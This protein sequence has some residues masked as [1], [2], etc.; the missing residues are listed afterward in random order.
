MKVAQRA[1]LVLCVFGCM[2]VASAAQTPV[3][4]LAVDERQGDQYGWAVD[5]ETAAAARARALG[6]DQRLVAVIALVPDHLGDSTTGRQHRFHLLGRR[7]QRLDHR[8]RVAGIGVLDGHADDRTRFQVH[9]WTDV[10]LWWPGDEFGGRGLAPEVWSGAAGVS[11]RRGSARLR[12][13]AGPTRSLRSP[14]AAD[15][16]GL[17]QPP[18]LH[19]PPPPHHALRPSRAPAS[20]PFPSSSF[21]AGRRRAAPASKPHLCRPSVTNRV[22]NHR[23]ERICSNADHTT[24][25]RCINNC[26]PRHFCGCVASVRTS[27]PARAARPLSDA[28]AETGRDPRRSAPGPRPESWR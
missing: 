12:G 27:L 8:R 17:L 14:T 19:D 13:R 1:C 2:A 20:T 22:A 24:H 15:F 28:D 16:A 10:G 18:R 21:A 25:H 3:G 26:L 9:R 5:Y 23:R 4:A 6:R 11:R 7:H